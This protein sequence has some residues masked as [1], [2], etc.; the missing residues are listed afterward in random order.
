VSSS[1]GT[2][3]RVRSTVVTVGASVGVVGL[4]LGAD[5]GLPEGDAVG[6]TVVGE[7]ELGFCVGVVEG[8]LVG[9]RVGYFVGK[10]VGL[11]E[12]APLVGASVGRAVV[13]V[14]VGSIV[15]F[16]LGEPVGFELGEAELGD[17]DVG[18]CVGAN[19]G[20]LL[21]GEVVGASE[22]GANV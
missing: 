8:S 21:V 1:I 7:R 12:G 3:V 4:E 11:I 9:R 14:P 6:R 13:G 16:E 15:G 20:L 10:G 2:V 17:D 19:V 5:E 22:D 18:S